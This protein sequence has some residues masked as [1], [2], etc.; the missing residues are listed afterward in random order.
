MRGVPRVAAVACTLCRT[1]EDPANLDLDGT[2]MTTQL[3]ILGSEEHVP[4]E[5][6]TPRAL[7]GS[8]VYRT[9]DGRWL[10]PAFRGSAVDLGSRELPGPDEDEALA[11]L[12]LDWVAI[13]R[14]HDWEDLRGAPLEGDEEWLDLRTAM[15]RVG[16]GP[17]AAQAAWDACAARPYARELPTAAGW[18]AA[19]WVVPAVADEPQ[20]C[21]ATPVLEARGLLRWTYIV[22]WADPVP[23][24]GTSLPTDPEP[25]D[26]GWADVLSR[27]RQDH[28]T[29]DS[30]QEAEQ[31]AI[32]L[33]ELEDL[34]PR[35]PLEAE[36][37]PL[38]D[39]DLAAAVGHDSP[40]VRAA[41]WFL[42]HDE[43]ERWL[44][45]T[46]AECGHHWAVE[47]EED[48]YEMEEVL[49]LASHGVANPV[50]AAYTRRR[51][52]TLA[53]GDINDVPLA[54]A[55]DL[56]DFLAFY[57]GW[58]TA[59]RPEDDFADAARELRGDDEAAPPDEG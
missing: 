40:L 45:C 44:A 3:R 32:E 17:A 1:R 39:R 14:S 43:A 6:C 33:L 53:F 42:L 31:V 12:V 56:D 10:A 34:G 26:L 46:Y 38:P 22:R 24:P 21:F 41:A 35:T 28:H 58:V 8:T 16:W 37:D 55:G 50:D 25:D 4:L 51:L 49:E 7:A 54:G 52:L 30:L 13:V 19:G 48:A 5:A 57:D 47:A 2:T 29:P 18:A 20:P 59:G 27:L 15:V 36:D 11:E 23:L 9:P